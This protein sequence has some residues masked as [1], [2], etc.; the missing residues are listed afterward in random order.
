MSLGSLKSKPGLKPT[1]PKATT[2]NPRPSLLGD[3]DAPNVN[4]KQEISGWDTSAGG[5]V[6]ARGAREKTPPR[7]IPVEPNR[8][9][10]A[11]MRRK[12]LEKAPHLQVKAKED[13]ENVKGEE[14]KFGLTILR[15]DGGEN[16]QEEA[17]KAEGESMEDVR[18]DLTDA[19]RLEKKA[20]EALL[21]GK[22]SDEH[23]IPVQ[24]D[25]DTFR[26]DV[27]DAPEAPSLAAYEAT[28]IEGFG[29]ALLRG[30]GWK[31]EDNTT[32]NAAAQ[33]TK[34][35]K[36]RP[37]LLGI[38]AKE[39]AAVGVELGE[40]GKKG[41]RGK[42][43]QGY[44][45]VAL[46]NKKT[47]ELITEEELKAKMEQQDK[48]VEDEGRLK[49]ERKEY[50]D[51][52]KRERRKDM[53][54]DGYDSRDRR[55][56]KEDYY[57]SDRRKDKRKDKYRDEEYD[58]ERRREKRRN[59]DDDYDSERRS[60][61]RRDRDRRE[62]SRSPRDEKR[63]SRKNRYRS[64]SRDSKR[65]HGRRDRSRGGDDRRERR[66]ER[67]YDDR[68]ERKKRLMDDKYYK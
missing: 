17:E 12:Q 62:R 21:N 5:A 11:D 68:D 35:P 14:M 55:R 16:G 9:W 24:A 28:P 43:V 59:R 61:K 53:K 8:D 33:K 34:E 37:A 32:K 19:Q 60:E 7:V 48:M 29:A 67:D 52:E 39:E 46:K 25:E 38:G 23:V 66:K 42:G 15:K 50:S 31:G 65:D 3:D 10:R 64:R 2:T 26:K 30:M 6:D 22:A 1:A 18:D 36:R 54:Y 41:K 56:E 44:N 58:S 4:Q 40:W 20:L 57:D 27:D 13:E 51:D 45:P 63:D 47:G 49:K